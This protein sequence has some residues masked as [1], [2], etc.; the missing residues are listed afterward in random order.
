MG[1]CLTGTDVVVISW[2][3]RYRVPFAEI[4]SVTVAGYLGLLSKGMIQWVPFVGSVGTLFIA[5]KSGRRRD[6]P[7]TIARRATA[8]KLAFR[9]RQ[10]GGIEQPRSDV[11]AFE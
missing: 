1:V 7:S 10:H 5:E 8:L 4:S 3:R 11:N 6:F 2:Y 9:V